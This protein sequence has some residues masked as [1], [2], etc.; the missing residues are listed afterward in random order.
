MPLKSMCFRRFTLNCFVFATLALQV[1]AVP[2]QIT[3]FLLPSMPMHPKQ[4]LAAANRYGAPLFLRK[5]HQRFSM[6]RYLLSTAPLCR[7]CATPLVAVLRRCRSK[8]CRRSAA[9]C[10]SWPFLCLALPPRIRAVNAMPSLS[11]FHLI[12]DV[13]KPALA[14]VAPLADAA[15]NAIIQPLAHSLFVAVVK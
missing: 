9:L 13:S 5:S 10:P 8:Q 12:G 4:N 3:A 14:A 1:A 11:G 15:Q 2:S 7:C 6:L